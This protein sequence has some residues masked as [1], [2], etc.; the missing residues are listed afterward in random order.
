[1]RGVI[2]AAPYRSHELGSLGLASNM[3][4]RQFQFPH[5]YSEAD[6]YTQIDLDRIFLDPY[7]RS[8]FE[9]Y[10]VRG[11]RS[12]PGWVRGAWDKDVLAFLS[13][14]VPHFTNSE[15]LGQWT[16]YRVMGT[17]NPSNGYLV[18]H[19]E[20]FSKHDQSET[21]VYTGQR[22]PNVARPERADFDGFGGYSNPYD[23]E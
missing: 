20:L 16:G 18:C 23:W 13:E 6:Q 17:V 19:L 11:E 2:I 5:T 21:P 1:M 10:G 3:Y 22:A 4:I 8:V 15:P 9:K 7:T 12:F 14:L